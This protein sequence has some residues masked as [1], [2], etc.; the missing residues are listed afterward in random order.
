MDTHKSGITD[1]PINI[2]SSK[3]FVFHVFLD[4]TVKMVLFDQ[5]CEKCMHGNSVPVTYFSFVIIYR[6]PLYVLS[7]IN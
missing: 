4:R 1:Y 3:W 6:L 7:F 2:T 5:W